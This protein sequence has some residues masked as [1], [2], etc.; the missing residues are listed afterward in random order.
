MQKGAFEH[1]EQR[2]L[3]AAREAQRRHDQ[4]VAELAALRADIAALKDR[5]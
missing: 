5:L 2:D 1:D 4:L 3:D